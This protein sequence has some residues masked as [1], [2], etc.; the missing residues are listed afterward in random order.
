MGLGTDI[1]NAEIA[2]A[3]IE[4]VL[5]LDPA[6]G[7]LWRAEA[8]IAEAVNSVGLEDVRIRQS[9]LLIRISENAAADI[10]ARGVESAYAIL[11]G[12]GRAGATRDPAGLIQTLEKQLMSAADADFGPVSLSREEILDI[13]AL[14]FGPSISPLI[15]ALRAA[16]RYALMTERQ[17]PALERMVFSI[18]EA[19]LR[20]SPEA[21]PDDDMLDQD[22]APP[23]DPLMR[24]APTGGWI[25]LPATALTTDGFS[26]WQ[27]TSLE[28]VERLVE[29]LNRSMSREIGRIGPIR[30]WLGKAE[31]L[32]G[33]FR[34]GSMFPDLVRVITR[35]PLITSA[36]L[37]HDLGAS[38]R[39]ATNLL[40]Q[41]V[42]HGLLVEVKMRRYARIWSTPGLAALL[43]DKPRQR[44]GIRGA[45]ASTSAPAQVPM[46][47]DPD[48]PAT[49][50]VQN[51]QKPPAFDMSDAFDEFDAIMAEADAMLQK[52]GKTRREREENLGIKL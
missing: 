24:Q 45:A 46:F 40:N 29:G 50:Q 27:P 25:M 41:A 52:V 39:T 35:R 12:L 48:I 31:S 1:L 2:A 28:G 42:D 5:R 19:G 9:D 14:G 20:Q 30:A 17:S 22:D 23:D 43:M 11:R 51:H 33:I 37:A 7:R 34:K 15:G 32:A 36:R 8:A 47:V 10:D 3:R 21:M 16:A 26:L 18:V 38:P 44:H 49:P 6:I 13:L 4:A